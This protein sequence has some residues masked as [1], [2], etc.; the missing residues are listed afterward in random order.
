M[1]N[2]DNVIY[3]SQWL[4]TGKYPYL[5]TI[6]ANDNGARQSRRYKVPVGFTT[7]GGVLLFDPNTAAI[8]EQ[9][10]SYRPLESEGWCELL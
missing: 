1:S 4:T 2:S 6:G 10:W 7:D 5:L 3:I 9:F 8:S